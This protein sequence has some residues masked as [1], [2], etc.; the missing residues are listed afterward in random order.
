MRKTLAWLTG[1]GCFM[2]LASAALANG[3]NMPVGVTD[4]SREIHSLHMT[5]FW[6]CVVIGVAVFGVMFFSLFRYR[7][8]QGAKSA[9]FHE[10][11][12]V[13]VIWTAIPLLILVGMAL[14]ATAT[15]H[16]MVDG[17]QQSC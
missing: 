11:T 5:I 9:N 15:L 13:E 8:S 6:I 12:T 4:V 2:G 1:G 7:R 3:W 14:P 16:G 17:P 10:H